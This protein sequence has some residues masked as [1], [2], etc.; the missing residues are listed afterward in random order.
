VLDDKPV[1]IPAEE[2]A[3]TQRIIDA[4]YRSSQL[5]REVKIS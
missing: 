3:V 1:P 5:G 4:L 2:A